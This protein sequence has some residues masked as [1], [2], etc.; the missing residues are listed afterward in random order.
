VFLLSRIREAYLESHDNTDSVV[1]GIT[2]TAR[3]ITSAALIMISVFLSF[4]FGDEPTIKMAGLGLATAVFVD[5]TIVR[6]VLV[7]STMRLIGDANWWLPRWLDRRLPNL[8]IEGESK[9]PPEELEG[10]R[11]QVPAT[12]PT[13]ELEPV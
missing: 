12:E 10:E 2:T 3:V 6:L 8:D 1:T 13:P 4:V 7:P 5:A 11:P 9:L